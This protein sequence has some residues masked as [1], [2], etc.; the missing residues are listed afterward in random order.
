MERAD[1]ASIYR[2]ELTPILVSSVQT[3]YS[4]CNGKG[5]MSRFNPAD[6]SLVIVDEAHHAVAA[7][8]RRVL[9]HYQQNP[10]CCVLGVTATPDRA[11]E[12][13]LGQVF[14]SVSYTYAID[15]AI[16]DGWLA[17]ISQRIVAADDIDYS[18]VRNMAGDLNE[19]DL[20]E[21]MLVEKSLEAIVAPTIEIAAG[22]KT[23]V[24]A[25]SVAHAE[26]MAAMFGR[27]GVRADFAS[28][29]TP[30]EVR[31]DMLRKFKHGSTQVLV[32]CALFTEGF[33]EPS[34]EVVAMG[35]PTKSRS[36]YTQMV[37]R[38]TRTLPGTVDGIESKEDRVSAIALSNKPFVEVLDFAGN[39]GRHKLMTAADILGG[40]YS[41]RVLELA[42]AE[43]KASGRTVDVQELLAKV[44]A[45]QIAREEERER[46]R[47][48]EEANRRHILAQV[49]YTTKKV[50]P[51]AR[52]EVR[53]RQT[54]FHHRIMKAS[55]K[56]LAFLKKLGYQGPAPTS[57]QHA[58]ALIELQ[59][60]TKGWKPRPK[61]EP[62]KGVTR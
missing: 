60:K 9:A 62:A 49:S 59:M 7:G 16:D 24:F 11:D 31:K 38:G 39:A 45:E 35:R 6:F 43:A 36:L 22:R 29:Q 3:Q 55:E 58:G 13:A 57:M 44:H 48:A 8:Y 42:K 26:R 53:P 15:K 50:N 5:R 51:F 34:I 33:D 52:E 61:P 20:E 56:Q 54:P 4:G 28:G 12:E 41:E 17:P 14:D 10:D 47:Q 18:Q 2:T 25:V 30:P 1:M 21:I 40:K 32:N 46:K 19:G 27:R 23:L 37:G